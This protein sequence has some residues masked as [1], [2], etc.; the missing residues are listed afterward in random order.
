M[1]NQQSNDFNNELYLQLYKMHYKSLIRMFLKN[2]SSIADAE[3]AVSDFLLKFA[4]KLSNEM[5]ESEKLSEAYIKGS[6]K[7]F[8]Y[9]CFR[10]KKPLSFSDLRS[11]RSDADDVDMANRFDIAG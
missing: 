3:D 2:S 8:I 6:F 11:D 10:K 5:K 1:K 7:N 9:D 4:G